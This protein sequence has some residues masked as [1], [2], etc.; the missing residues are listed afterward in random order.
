MGKHVLF[1]LKPGFKETEDGPFYCPD[2]A[3]VEGFL[4]YEP[5]IEEKIEVKRIEFPKP[6]QGVIDLVGEAHQGCPVLVIDK[7]GDVPEEATVSEETGRAYISDP[8]QIC[9][10]LGRLFGVVRPQP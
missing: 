3:G 6:R 7:D 5:A 1:L 4:K 10:V 9:N 8:T 2:S